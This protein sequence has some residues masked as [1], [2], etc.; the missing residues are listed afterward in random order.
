MFGSLKAAISGILA[1]LNALLPQA[2]AQA[3]AA[4]NASQAEDGLKIMMFMTARFIPAQALTS[5]HASHL[6]G[7]HGPVFLIAR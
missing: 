2:S 1:F 4:Q 6:Q 5:R 7:V 3:I